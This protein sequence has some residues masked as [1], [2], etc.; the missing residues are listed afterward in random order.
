MLFNVRPRTQA[1][2]VRP[3]PDDPLQR[4]PKRYLRALPLGGVLALIMPK[5]PAFLRRSEITSMVDPEAT[6]DHA[7]CVPAR[8]WPTLW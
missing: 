8:A 6:A 3:Q 2:G 1:S 7:P 5:D 4:Q